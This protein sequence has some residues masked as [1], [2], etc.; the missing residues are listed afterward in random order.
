MKYLSYHTHTHT[1][2]QCRQSHQWSNSDDNEILHGHIGRA[3]GVGI[4]WDFLTTL[5]DVLGNNNNPY[6]FFCLFWSRSTLNLFAAYGNAIIEERGPFGEK[7]TYP[8]SNARIGEIFYWGVKWVEC[9]KALLESPS[10]Y[11]YWTHVCRVNVTGPA[12]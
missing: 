5:I 7:V 12:R 3:W 10:K 2:S 1:H 9:I 4:S 11:T 8:C 6:P